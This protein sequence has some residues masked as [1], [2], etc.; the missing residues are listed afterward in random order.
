MSIVKKN[1][2]A[3][4]GTKKWRKNIDVTD[5]M[6]EVEE[7]Q[8][9]DK[10]EK[11]AK[12]KLQNNKLFYI[13][14]KPD[15]KLKERLPLDPNRFKKRPS[16]VPL[17]KADA[18]KL[19]KLAQKQKEKD[20][21]K[22]NQMS[23][24]DNTE[25][26][27][28]KD[29]WEAPIPISKRENIP[30]ER[31]KAPVVLVPHAGQSYNPLFKAHKDLLEKIVDEEKEKEMNRNFIEYEREKTYQPKQKRRIRNI[32]ER[33]EAEEKAKRKLERQ[34]AH[35]FMY[36]PKIVKKMDKQQEEHEKFL[37]ELE[38]QEKEEKRLIEEGKLAKAQKVG[39]V[40]YEYKGTD[41]KLTSELTPNLRTLKSAGS[42]IRDQ[43]DSVFRRGIIEP[44]VH[45]K[46]KKKSSMPKYKKHNTDRGHRDDEDLKVHK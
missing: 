25:S 8:K 22:L 42:L 36:L 20:E 17:P 2:R 30:L 41:F 18:K 7:Q 11:E 45:G 35:D 12:E 44:P 29:V 40:K 9:Q 16:N 31:V 6:L 33:L 14:E 26:E 1:A 37:K 27:D 5:L 13:D 24:T 28:V 10:L 43:Y 4:K 34:Q 23:T 32:K 38:E 3:T 39:R 19:N 46:K 21:E 15:A